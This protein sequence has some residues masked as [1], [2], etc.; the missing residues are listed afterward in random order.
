MKYFAILTVLILIV[1]LVGVGYMYMT[2]NIFV[3]AVGVVA[4]DAPSQIAL[5]EELR[6]QVHPRP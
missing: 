1:T 4:T 5:F 6:E 2:A 3:D